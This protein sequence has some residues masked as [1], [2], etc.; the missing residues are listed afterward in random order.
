MRSLVLSAKPPDASPALVTV[1][2]PDRVSPVARFSATS[3]AASP[4][5]VATSG[6]VA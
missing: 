3:T 1:T 5:A 6:P 4:G 2:S